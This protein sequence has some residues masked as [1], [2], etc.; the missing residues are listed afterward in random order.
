MKATELAAWI[1]ACSGVGSLCWNVYTKLT[2]GPKL[3]VTAHAGLIEMPPR[4]YNPSFLRITVQNIGTEKT[5]INN[6]TFHDY[7]YRQRK[8]K[9]WW[10][11]HL[12]QREFRNFVLNA[13]EGP[14]I[15]YTLE[16]GSQWVGSMEQDERFDELLRSGKLWCAVHH[17]FSS[18]QRKRESITQL[19]HPIQKRKKA[20]SPEIF[21]SLFRID[22]QV[23][24]QKFVHQVGDITA[25]LF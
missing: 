2:S 10:A 16:V 3:R 22:A 14:Q 6:V 25:D 19:C 20:S 24:V 4:P 21:F 12:R 5:M 23:C 13:H 1:G 18:T 15:P 17:S 8:S 11:E 7:S 9:T